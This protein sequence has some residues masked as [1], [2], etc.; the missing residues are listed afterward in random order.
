MEK[1]NYYYKI[2]WIFF[3]SIIVYFGST[4]QVKATQIDY[5]LKDQMIILDGNDG[6]V[7]VNFDSIQGRNFLC[8]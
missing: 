2:I 3:I 7:E 1:L 4:I 6:I 5:T 8:F